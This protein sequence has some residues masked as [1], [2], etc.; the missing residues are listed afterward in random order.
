[1]YNA[2]LQKYSLASDKVE[3]FCEVIKH[4]HLS[5][6]PIFE[7]RITSKTK[8]KYLSVFI[9]T[10]HIYVINVTRS[11]LSFILC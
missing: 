3:N 10:C 2:R 9:L 4:H 11:T 8:P 1:M 7:L 6:E 5:A